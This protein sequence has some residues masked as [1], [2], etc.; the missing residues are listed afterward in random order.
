MNINLEKI[1]NKINGRVTDKQVSD[2]LGG[3]IAKALV[4]F[5]KEYYQTTASFD[6]G[7]LLLESLDNTA[8][9][10]KVF[11][12]ILIMDL[13]ED[14]EINAL[15]NILNIQGTASYSIREDICGRNIK[16]K[17][18]AISE[19]LD[20]ELNYFI[21]DSKNQKTQEHELVSPYSPIDIKD[22][23][24]EIPKE[25]LC[26]HDYHTNIHFHPCSLSVQW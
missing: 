14:S 25:F 22:P 7:K 13:L 17:A 5:E 18:K 2:I 21:E 4:S 23:D 26:L 3:I 19:L 16:I 6:F 8:L 24:I 9:S 11:I 15:M 1:Y 20:L 10:N 12:E